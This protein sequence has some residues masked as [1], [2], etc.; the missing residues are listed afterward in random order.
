MNAKEKKEVEELVNATWENSKKHVFE[1]ASR[2]KT[3]KQN[4]INYINFHLSD[5]RS[6]ADQHLPKRKTK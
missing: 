1:K 4:V 2:Y 5:M 3:P 6:E